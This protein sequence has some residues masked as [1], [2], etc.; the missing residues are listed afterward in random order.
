MNEPASCPELRTA[1]P[2]AGCLKGSGMLCTESEQQE[3]VEGS[4]ASSD[5][6]EILEQH[7]RQ[8]GN[9]ICAG[10]LEED[11]GMLAQEEKSTL[12]GAEIERLLREVLESESV[13]F[14]AKIVDFVAENGSANPAKQESGVE[15]R[16]LYSCS[17]ALIRRY[18]YWSQAMHTC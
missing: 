13:H 16:S 6:Q 15:C 9:H 2:I 11:A 4:P 1:L 3:R 12:S 18:T 17:Q 5:F 8:K 10:I 7:A 14:H